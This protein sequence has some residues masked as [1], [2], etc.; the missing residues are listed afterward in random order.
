MASE[1]PQEPAEEAS[2]KLA[3]R[4][5]K[6]KNEWCV[7]HPEPAWW[8]SRAGAPAWRCT[9]IPTGRG[10]LPAP[11]APGYNASTSSTRLSTLKIFSSTALGSTACVSAWPLNSRCRLVRSDRRLGLTSTAVSGLTGA[12]GTIRSS[13]KS[14]PG[15]RKSSGHQRSALAAGC[16]LL[17]AGSRPSPRLRRSDRPPASPSVAP[18]AAP[19]SAS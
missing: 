5:H 6:T 1:K 19:S 18:L 8:Q 14:S 11:P 3:S 9:A 10:A 16:P 2:G 15:R 17:S 13:P 12:Y 4:H 7:W